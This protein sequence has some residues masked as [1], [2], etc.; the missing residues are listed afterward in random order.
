[1]PVDKVMQLPVAGQPLWSLDGR[2]LY[3][4]ARERDGSSSI[5]QMPVNGDPER[6]LIWFRDPQRQLF[7]TTISMSA[8]DF[9]VTIGERESDVWTM[10]LK[11]Q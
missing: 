5:W 10:E 11:K 2:H 1:M 9:Y 7:R 4:A 8:T 6:R 3:V